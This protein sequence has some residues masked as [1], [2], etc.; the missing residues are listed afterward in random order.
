MKSE[1]PFHLSRFLV[2]GSVLVVFFLNLSV[3]YSAQSS[4][5]DVTRNPSVSRTIDPA[6]IKPDLV[7]QTPAWSSNPKAGDVVGTSSILNITVKNTGNSS[8]GA[9]LLKI[10]CSPMTGTACPTALNGSINV[11]SLGSGQAMTFAWPSATPSQ[12]WA[13]GKYRLVFKA[14]ASNQV[15]ESSEA[16]NTTQLIF[17]VRSR[18]QVQTP[19]VQ[20]VQQ[21]IVTPVINTD[22][23]VVSLALTPQ[24]PVSGQNVEFAAVIRNNGRTK[25]PRADTKFT[26]WDTQGGGAGGLFYV[27]SHP[28]PPLFPNQTHTLKTSTT[29]ITFGNRAGAKVEID[30]QGKIQESD[31]QNNEKTVHFDIQCKPELALYDYT[32]AKPANISASTSVNEK[33]KMTVWVYNN[34]GCFSKAAKFSIGGDELFPTVYDIPPINPRQRVGIPI[35]TH[36]WTNPGTK[37]C[38]IIV[39]TTNT[40]N[41]SIETNNKMPLVITVN[42]AWPETN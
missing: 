27:P 20:P 15:M 35:T 9:S 36:R 24:H 11:Q 41:E 18:I 30:P 7:V 29:F 16:N 2:A 26:F 8:A 5:T 28:V 12:I 17:T 3:A 34:A 40:N 23:E 38:T 31:R 37:N 19:S 13:P 39:D 33:L 14:D 6:T 32:K 25:T 22:L 10:E 4:R 1:N 42:A 21:P